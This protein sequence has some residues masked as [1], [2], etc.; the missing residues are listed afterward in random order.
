MLI[1]LNVGLSLGVQRVPKR[2]CVRCVG[3]TRDVSI[4]R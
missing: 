2:N 3:I 1:L 4:S